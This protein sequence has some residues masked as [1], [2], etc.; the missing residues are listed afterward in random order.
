MTLLLVPVALV[1][2]LTLVL[3]RVHEGLEPL[4]VCRRGERGAD[5][6]ND[7][8]RGRALRGAHL[9]LRHEERV[10]RRA[11]VVP[12]IEVQREK[13]AA[14]DG[15]AGGHLCPQ[16]RCVAIQLRVDVG[17]VLR[18][19]HPVAI[20]TLEVRHERGILLHHRVAVQPEIERVARLDR[21]ALFRTLLLRFATSGDAPLS[22]TLCLLTTAS[23]A[24]REEKDQRG[25][26]ERTGNFHES[27]STIS[28]I[29]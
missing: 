15:L 12:R 16:L 4:P 2:A 25:R 19:P 8:L 6:G 1:E 18:R 9:A 29:P 22:L 27:A 5:H 11:H 21:P 23:G 28:A 17:P 3:K 10:Y 14:S 26:A 20:A 7:P 24:R 13:L